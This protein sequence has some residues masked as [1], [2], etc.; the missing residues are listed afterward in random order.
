MRCK[1]G[2]APELYSGVKKRLDPKQFTM[3]PNF[4]IG[5]IGNTRLISPNS[6]HC[7]FPVEF[8]TYRSFVKDKAS[9]WKALSDWEQRYASIMPSPIAALSDQAKDALYLFCLDVQFSG[10]KNERSPLRRP[11]ISD[12]FHAIKDDQSREALKR[13]RS[14]CPDAALKKTWGPEFKYTPEQKFRSAYCHPSNFG[15]NPEFKEDGKYST[16]SH[17]YSPFTN[18][19]KTY[20]L[21]EDRV[22]LYVPNIRFE[23][24]REG[25]LENGPQF[26]SAM[27]MLGAFSSE[28]A[29]SAPSGPVTAPAPPPLPPKK[30]T[31]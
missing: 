12:L 23:W 20:F 24:N 11:T 27:K 16:R 26:L 15:P 13:A 5:L 10:A 2:Q 21:V 18:G 25:T 30:G 1:C 3:P 29:P 14:I 31:S 9:Q 6:Q 7:T 8:G 17:K 28:T 22:A 19:G 4:E